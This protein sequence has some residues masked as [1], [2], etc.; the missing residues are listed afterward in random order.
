M[1]LTH[2]DV[3][4]A[5][6]DADSKTVQRAYRKTALKVHPDRGG[7]HE[8][9]VRLNESYGVLADPRQRAEYDAWLERQ[10]RRARDQRAGT[11]RRWGY[12]PPPP[13]G[14]PP[15]S[16]ETRAH[17]R[18]YP[19]YEDLD[20]WLSAWDLAIESVIEDVRGTK[21][22]TQQSGRFVVVDGDSA[23]AQL[24]GMAGAAGGM[25]VLAPIWT[26]VPVILGPIA[27]ALGWS[28]GVGVHW[29]IHLSTL[30]EPGARRQE[31]GA[32]ASSE[33]FR[34]AVGGLGCLGLPIAGSGGFVLGA[35]CGLL[36]GGT[37]L[38][39]ALSSALCLGISGGVLAAGGWAFALSMLDSKLDKT[40]GG[41]GGEGR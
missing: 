9:M 36:M 39:D 19:R 23:S 1:V 24:F 30:E 6:R 27:G 32:V 5:P 7:S 37:D 40:G 41:R 15:P 25:V 13:P 3:V 26:I 33:G 34:T 38:G 20:E 28:V 11:S 8:A 10:E 16:E 22:A 12:R 4:G 21:Y 35:A 2:Y 31:I 18:D 17:A 29:V 14:P